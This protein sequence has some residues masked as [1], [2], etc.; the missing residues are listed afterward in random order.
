MLI[1]GALLR[2][3][4]GDSGEDTQAKCT[5]QLLFAQFQKQKQKTK[6]E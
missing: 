2:A 1:T 5:R 3:A 6:S 4:A